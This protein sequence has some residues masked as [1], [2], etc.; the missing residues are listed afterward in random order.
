MPIVA[1][2]VERLNELLGGAARSMDE[3][4][5]ALGNLGCDVEDTA[6]LMQYQCPVCLYLSERLPHEAAPRRC[7]QCEHEQPAALPL[8]GRRNVIRLDLLADRPDLFDVGGISRAL[9]GLFGLERGLPRY[10]VETGSITV[11][12]D[13]AL[14]RPESYWPLIG[15]AQLEVPPLDQ[16][17]LRE[18]MRLQESLHWGIGRDRKLC[19]IGVY[20][21]DAI[22]PPIRFTRIE[23]N[24]RRFVPLAHG[25][26][27]LTARQILEQHPKGR[28]YAHLLKDFVGYPLLVDS[29]E[30]VLSMPPVIN[31]EETRVKV[32][33]RRLFA[34]VTGVAA[35]SVR[36][37][38][39]TLVCSLAELGARVRSVQVLRPDGS[40]ERWPDLEP[41]SHAIDLDEARIWLGLDLD[42][43]HMIGLLGKMRL[44]VIGAGPKVQVLFPSFRTDVRHAVDLFA[45]L[46]IGHGYSSMP[47]RSIP[48][49]TQSS[50]RPEERLS[51]R[52]RAVMTGLRFWEVMSLVQT[53]PDKHFRLLRR[54]PEADHVVIANPK[55][56]EVTVVRCHLMTGLLE[57]LQKNRRK[58]VP[59]QFFEVGNVVRLDP[60]GETGT[61]EER[62]L[63]FAVAGPEAGYANVRSVVDGLCRELGAQPNY[64]AET[65][66]TFVQGRCAEFDAPGPGDLHLRG[67]LGELH[68][69]VLENFSIPHP[70]A[71]AE[72]SLC[73][74]V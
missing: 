5:E 57:T 18:L 33:T 12:V 60:D 3:L 63:A 72:V 23:P 54:E 11:A 71:L 14:E 40:S 34:E 52:V 24:G 67:V 46:A 10:P 55:N 65:R 51:N 39:H 38:L 16:E 70:V 26:E 61:R 48:T 53:T 35:A 19:A 56:V 36:A 47:M 43:A 50:E 2:G 45:D 59:Q 29:K 42:D 37:A 44:E 32:G 41:K 31:S 15:A 8:V 28:A 17:G 49:M 6:E 74:V 66:S 30:R 25:Q 13:P 22:A 62:R 69:E 1:I 9:R 4:A 73:R 64:R 27:P 20:D 58:A 68:P 7:D 21:L